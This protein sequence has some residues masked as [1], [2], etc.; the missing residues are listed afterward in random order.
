DGVA[1]SGALPSVSRGR[2]RPRPLGPSL[3]GNQF[4]AESDNGGSKQTP[5]KEMS[6]EVR[7]LLAFLLMRAV[8]FVFQYLYPHQTPP[9]PPQKQTPVA[10]APATPTPPLANQA[11][12]PPPAAEAAVTAPPTTKAITSK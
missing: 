11:A 7:L 4:M 5:P 9:K 3:N 1:P 10:T 12:P 6:M 8:M 2:L